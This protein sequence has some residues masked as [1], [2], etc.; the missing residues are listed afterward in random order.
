MKRKLILLLCVLALAVA[1]FAACDNNNNNSGN[2]GNNSGNCEHTFSDEWYSNEES[3]WHPATCEHAETERSDF[4]SHADTDEDGKCDICEFEVGHTHTFSDGWTITETHHWKD[5][6]CSHT[7]VKQ[8]ESTH[9]DEDMDGSCDVCSGH[10]HKANP[11]G[12]CVYTDCG[13]KV[14]DID[15]TSLEDLVAAVLFQKYLVNGGSVNYNFVGR[16]NTGINYTAEKTDLVEYVFGK[17]NYTHITVAT[18]SKN[19][20]NERDGSF[21]SWH[22]LSGEDQAFGIFKEDEND[23]AV[24]FAEAAKLNGYYIALSTLAGDYGVEETLY[25]LYEAAIS[26]TVNELVVIPD[27]AEN[28][29][30]F[31]YS[32]KTAIVNETQIAVGDNVGSMVYNVSYYEVEVTFTYSD[33]FALTSLDIS[34]DCYT[35][36]PG[37]ADGVGFL[38]KDVDIAYD[39][40]TEEITFIEYYQDAEGNW[41]TRPTDNRTPDTYTISV[42][43]TLGERTEENPHPRSNF[44]PTGF[45]LFAKKEYILDDKGNDIGFNLKDKITGS[46]TTSV[47]SI[48]NIY[49][50]NYTPENTSLHFI[51]DQVTYKLYLNGVEVENPDDNNNQTAV[52]MFTYSGDL[53]SFFVIPRVDGAYKLEIYVMGKLMKQVNILAGDVDEENV[54]LKDNEFAVKVTESY[55]WSNEV[56]FTATQAGTY[57]F[58]L[59][60]GVGFMDA[61]GYDA[62]ENTPATD[63]TP[64]PYFDYNNAKNKDGSYNPGSFSLELEAGETVRFYVN[65][66][67]KGV[68]V[69]RWAVV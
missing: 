26:D 35:N 59:P 37:V 16:S 57:Y 36:D 25:A 13:Q 5:V 28:K 48:V 22:Q 41:L 1:C 52:A 17:D 3:H 69:I 42:T 24:D 43:Q 10:V 54:E 14:R 15:E 21:E 33:D 12:Y 60:A 11:A 29:V 9:S 62:A 39:P 45:D 56:T 46:I 27:T 6:T 63:D 4:G 66:M 34:V 40:D 38:Y 18:N 51:A 49:V 31:K 32:Y 58:N 65:A 30:T 67:K 20:T 8:G 2:G 68:Y 7:D 61:D 47:G 19:G 23:L 53:R 55:E 64:E 44:V 50:S